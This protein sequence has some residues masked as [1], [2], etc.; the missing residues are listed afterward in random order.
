MSPAR[1]AVH[2]LF[3]TM[4]VALTAAAGLA[5]FP[6]AVVAQGSYCGVVAAGPGDHSH[7]ATGYWYTAEN[8]ERYCRPINDASHYVCMDEH[9]RLPTRTVERTVIPRVRGTATYT[10]DEVTWR[11]GPTYYSSARRAEWEARHGIE[12]VALYPPDRTVP[13]LPADAV[14][15]MWV[16]GDGWM[17]RRR[18][19]TVPWGPYRDGTPTTV[20]YEVTDIAHNSTGDCAPVAGAAATVRYDTIP[21]T[22]LYV[23]R[24][25]DQQRCDAEIT[26]GQMFN[27]LCDG[28]TPVPRRSAL[29]SVTDDQ[30]VQRARH[31][32]IIEDVD[33]ERTTTVCTEVEN[34]EGAR[35]AHTSYFCEDVPS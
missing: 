26:N 35:E 19:V 8:G 15:R 17:M 11:P 34:P 30:G 2:K 32:A 23:D 5:V 27:H 3:A 24:R 12:L 13:A 14:D 25:T 7:V 20:T 21:S 31:Q 4:L 10:F 33:G 29:P 16:R 28:A 22:G 9:G 18:S 1:P 6:D